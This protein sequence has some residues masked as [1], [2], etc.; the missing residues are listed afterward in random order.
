MPATGLAGESRFGRFTRI[1][2]FYLVAPVL[3]VLAVPSAVHII[4]KPWFG[5]HVLRLEVASVDPGS[6]ADRAGLRTGDAIAAVD[7]RTFSRTVDFYLAEAGRYDRRPRTVTIIR[8]GE[9]QVVEVTPRSAPR[10]MM[11]FWLS[12]WLAGLAFV[13]IG[14]WVLSR[15]HDI[16][17][18]NFFWLSVAFAFFLLDVPDLPSRHYLVV[19]EI[20]RDVAQLF[21][22]VFFLRFF[23][24][25]P[26]PPAG[27]PVRRRQRLLFLPAVALTVA[28][29]LVRALRAPEDAPAVVALQIA[30]LVYFVAYFVAGL[31]V[32]A[33]KVL[34][35]DRPVLHT[36]LRVMLLGLVAGLGPF[37]LALTAA[38]VAP[39]NPLPWEYLGFTLLLVPASFALAI[40]RYGALDTAFVV[41][42]SLT[43]G[44]LT[45]VVLGLYFVGVGVL[46]K[47]L[48]DVYQVSHLPAVAV[49]IGL[50]SL[51]VLPLRRR[52]QEGLDRT[53]YPSRRAD[54]ETLNRLAHT[55][56]REMDATSAHHL[57]LARLEALYRPRGLA[58][59]LAGEDPP[60][61]YRVAD[62]A[63]ESLRPEPGRLELP[64]ESDLVLL[65]DHVRRPAFREEYEDAL[66]PG[67]VDR[68]SEE[69]L[70]GLGTELLV[71]LVTGN[72]LLGFLAF[73]P[74]RSGDLY[75]QVDLAHLAALA[76]QLAPQLDNLRLYRESLE[77]QQLETELA[78]AR[79]IQAQLVP[80]E[81]LQD[82]SYVVYGRNAACRQV[83]GDYFDYFALDG[84]AV[85]LCIADVAGKGIPA[86][87][88]TASVRMSLRAEARAGRP[89]EE[90]VALL[91]RSLR[92]VLGPAQF[93]CFFY[94]VFEPATGMLHYCNAGM[95]PPLVFRDG[96][97]RDSLRMGGPV[98]GAVEDFPYR[99]GTVRLEPG[100]TLLAYTDGITEQIAPASGEFYDLDRLVA[101][102]HGALGKDLPPQDICHRIFAA[103]A[104]FG[105]AEAS[106]DQTVMVL[107][108]F[109]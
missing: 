108:Y 28:A 49:V 23:L 46:G 99:G 19:K 87:M 3:I 25:F 22:P 98:L 73:G 75:T 39:Q 74:K 8:D 43:Y 32:F 57:L 59:V 96:E 38:N 7:G 85:A 15:R 62:A 53:F 10:S 11:V 104:E 82:T 12:N 68:D 54:R 64:A 70:D 86:A 60:V 69:L 91:G 65:L 40:V 50:C 107:R 4:Q 41:R 106:D 95:D 21:W 24:L 16:V 6:P 88:L 94:G 14:W 103:V 56:A 51:S 27:T 47:M 78:V 2:A 33:R 36:K 52:L 44:L 48:A 17:G 81:P 83:G 9:P 79:E 45:L 26:A 30:A 58:L 67:P 102:A 72:R 1:V 71:P 34:R 84:G 101:V 89:P 42:V 90:V 76:L 31:V 18:R 37:L 105:G 66:P 109:A 61:R 5:W 100:D 20:A 80:G 29:L 77:R 97:R 92:A 35:R 13:M 63:P 55:L 93:V